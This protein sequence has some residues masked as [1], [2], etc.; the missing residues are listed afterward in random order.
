VPEE[1]WQGLEQ[2]L[3]AALERRFPAIA[4]SGDEVHASDL[5]S[6]HAPFRKG[7]VSERIALRNEWL[8][9]AT[10]HRLKL[11]YRSIEKTRYQKWHKDALGVG[12][13]INPYVAAFALVSRV[14][15]DY[16]ANL[17][18]KALGMLIADENK[19]I[20]H[21][22]EKSIKVLRGEAGPLRLSQI[23]E[24]VFF[25]DSAKSRILQLCD[26]CVF[27]VRKKEEASLGLSIKEGDRE[28]VAL[29]EPL[30]HRG[31][32]QLID[33]LTWLKGQQAQKK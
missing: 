30:V 5:R 27:S 2:D 31:N 26:L 15:D 25:I 12:V 11:I 29:I 20:V 7:A 17:P 6:G 10:T 3:E 4:A 28:G 18:E 14:I 22:I 8:T 1:C 9:I 32:E 19:E 13:V 24:K 21:D 16:L 33:V 23:V